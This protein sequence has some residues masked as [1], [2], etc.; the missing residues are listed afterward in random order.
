MSI[1]KRPLRPLKSS[2]LT[3]RN[4]RSGAKFMG[5]IDSRPEGR[6]QRTVFDSVD[7][8]PSFSPGRSSEK[9][10]YTRVVPSGDQ[11]G[12]SLHSWY[13]FGKSTAENFAAERSSDARARCVELNLVVL[14]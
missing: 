2:P 4:R 3:T 1:R 5:M 8:I 6:N 9:D 10:R 12:L 7:R 13:S 11:T 14:A